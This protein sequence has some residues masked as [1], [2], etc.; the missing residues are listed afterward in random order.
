MGVL[1]ISL[2]QGHIPYIALFLAV[3]FS[4]Y[5]LLKKLNPISSLQSNQFESLIMVPVALVFLFTQSTDW[6][7]DAN[8]TKSALLLIGAGIVTGLPL[9]FFAEA[10]KRIPFYLMGFFQFL[11]PTMQFLTGVLIFS[12][13]L[14]LLKLKGFFFIWVAGFLLITNTWFRSHQTKKLAKG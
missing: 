13:P 6:V 3:T 5:G 1:I 4:G 2:D 10:A 9:I 11:S 7:T 12:E 14:S 8:L